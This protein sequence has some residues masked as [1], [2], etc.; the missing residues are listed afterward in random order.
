MRHRTLLSTYAVELLPSRTVVADS[1]VWLSIWIVPFI[2]VTDCHGAFQCRPL[3]SVPLGRPNVVTTP[4]LRADTIVVEPRIS[5]NSAITPAT[6]A[7]RS[8]RVLAGRVLGPQHAEH[9]HHGD[10]EQ[11]DRDPN[12]PRHLVDPLR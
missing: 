11:D 2:S 7:M 9:G 4:M 3:D 1:P 8:E 10:D 6:T 12:L 5:T